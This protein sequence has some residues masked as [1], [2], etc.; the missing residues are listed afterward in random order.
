MPHQDRAAKP[1]SAILIGEGRVGAQFACG[2]NDI[3]L[4]GGEAGDFVE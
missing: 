1:E 2:D 3:V 4:W